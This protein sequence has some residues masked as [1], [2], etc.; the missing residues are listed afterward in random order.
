VLDL[1]ALL[2]NFNHS[3]L[4]AAPALSPQASTDAAGT[5]FRRAGLRGSLHPEFAGASGIRHID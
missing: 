3:L 1:N 2:P 4:A 5:A